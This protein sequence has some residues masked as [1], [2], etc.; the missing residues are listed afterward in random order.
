MNPPA[1]V[2]TAIV[3]TG[4]PLP[5]TAGV[6]TLEVIPVETVGTVA[7][8]KAQVAPGRGVSE[9]KSTMSDPAPEVVAGVNVRVYVA[10]ALGAEV[11]IVILRV[12][13]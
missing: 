3:C 9:Q 10:W 8:E 11:L 7:A 13:T 1:I 5:S 4:V 12:V 6:P 2:V